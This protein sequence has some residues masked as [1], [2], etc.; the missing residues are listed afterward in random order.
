V[1]FWNHGGILNK[2]SHSDPLIMGHE[3]SGVIHDVGLGVTSV[4]RGDHVAIEPGIPCRLCKNCKAGRYN[5][6]PGMRF[7]ADPPHSHGTLTKFFKI[8][9]D[10]CYKIPQSMGLDEAVLVEPLAV[11]VHAARLANVKIGNDVV[12]FGAGTVGLLCAAVAKAMGARSVI[13]VDVN[14]S[15]LDFAK[16][17]AATGTFQSSRSDTPE[18]MALRIKSQP[19]M[20]EGADVVLEATGVESCIQ[21]G[22][23]VLK[24]GGVFV[25]VGL[26]KARIQ[27]PVVTLSAKEIHMIGCFRY[28]PGDYDLALH[29]LE[30]GN[31]SVKE[32]ITGVEPFERATE[33]WERTKRGDGL[34]NLI[35]GPVD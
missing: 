20:E 21:A 26:G 19:S 25:Q 31:V 3:A 6:C 29:L 4:Q 18:E 9:E 35:R 30:S 13:S 12:I 33:A 32:L 7:A 10:L 34:K 27:F 11:A 15:R 22:I 23:H 1:H 14:G 28:G 16:S 5:L 2:V 17:F 8:S 24:A